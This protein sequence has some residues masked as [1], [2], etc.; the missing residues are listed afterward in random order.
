[1]R[2]STL[3]SIL[4]CAGVF[5]A[6]CGEPLEVDGRTQGLEV[7]AP[8]PFHLPDLT[9]DDEAPPIV[10]AVVVHD[11]EWCREQVMDTKGVCARC[12]DL[13][14]SCLDACEIDRTGPRPPVGM[15]PHD[16]LPDDLCVRAQSGACYEA[17]LLCAQCTSCQTVVRTPVEKDCAELRARCFIECDGLGPNGCRLCEARVEA[18]CGPR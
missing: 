4:T 6:G 3:L 12:D 15:A 10:N 8:R 13:A 1:M 11:A 5:A 17:K 16:T 14:A 18:E 2:T 7:P 9:P